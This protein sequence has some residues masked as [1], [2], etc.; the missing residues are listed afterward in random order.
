MACNLLLHTLHTRLQTTEPL[1]GL[2]TEHVQQHAIRQHVELKMRSGSKICWGVP[3]SCVRSHSEHNEPL[4][5][6]FESVLRPHSLKDLGVVVC[7]TPQTAYC[8]HSGPNKLDQGGK[9][10]QSV[11]F[12][13]TKRRR[14]ENALWFLSHTTMMGK[15]WLAEKLQQL[16]LPTVFKQPLSTSYKWPKYSIR[17]FVASNLY[18]FLGHTVKSLPVLILTR[19]Y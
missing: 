9:W 4:Q 17:V 10:T 16:F 8:V 1:N 14:C 6:V 7:S 3:S 11:R 13:Q 2:S 19:R 15:E 18:P 12:H 5:S